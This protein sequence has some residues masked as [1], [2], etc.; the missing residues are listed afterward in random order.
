MDTCSIAKEF[1]QFFSSLYNLPPSHPS[2]TD[3]SF[4]DKV[5]AYLQKSA[6]P[7]LSDQVIDELECP[8]TVEERCTAVANLYWAKARGLMVSQTNRIRNNFLL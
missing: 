4:R 3:G 2:D 7:V 6:L 8:I 5:E 1:H